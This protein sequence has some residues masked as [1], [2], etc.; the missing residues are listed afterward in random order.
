MESNCALTGPLNLEA[1]VTRN[2]CTQDTKHANT[3]GDRRRFW[4]FEP[5]FQQ[6]G[7]GW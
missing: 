4:A 5:S 1:G 3:E 2:G 7:Q 6:W